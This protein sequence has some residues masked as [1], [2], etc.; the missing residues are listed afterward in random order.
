[1]QGS[2]STTDKT[3]TSLD[4]SPMQC[5][6]DLGCELPRGGRHARR[7]ILMRQRCASAAFIGGRRVG[8]AQR[9]VGANLGQHA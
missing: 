3:M 5:V 9:I 4:N 8:N 7:L 6:Q 2:G 1:M